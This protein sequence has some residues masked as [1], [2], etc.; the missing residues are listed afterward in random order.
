MFLLLQTIFIY[1]LLL[2]FTLF[3]I[4]LS[5]DLIL[6]PNKIC[7]TTQIQMSNHINSI[8]SSYIDPRLKLNHFTI[9]GTHNSYH[10]QNLIY[11]YQHEILDG[12]LSFGVRQLELDIHLM[13]DYYPVY[14]I[15]LFD[16]RTNCYCLNE[17]F[18]KVAQWK[19]K[20]PSHFPM[21]LFIEIKQMFYE[22]L[23]TGLNGGVKCHHF[24]QLKDEFSQIF[25][26][27]TF[28]LPPQIQ[29]NQQSLKVALKQQKTDELSGDYSYKNYGW[30][31]LYQSL[32]KILPIFLD[33]HNIGVNL[34]PQCEVL[35]DF[36]LLAQPN[37]NLSYSSI[38]SFANAVNDEQDLIDSSM[39]GQIIRILLGY[40]NSN[41]DQIY[42]SNKKYGIHIISSDSLEC[43]DTRLCQLLANDFQNATVLCNNYSAPPFC[44]S[45]IPF[46]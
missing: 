37:L 19:N 39:N 5:L 29:G 3:L 34:Y 17:C 28:I 2:T 12:Q 23:S 11:K 27:D 1:I 26:S 13:D 46:L 14:H 33:V 20:Y 25:S 16:D 21:F 15:Q 31:P 36:F 4:W 8:N 40:G 30:P 44:N 22:D 38:I 10:Y 35:R 24:Q 45:S 42:L 41:L 7:S 6:Y 18:M 43:N 32:G 9:L